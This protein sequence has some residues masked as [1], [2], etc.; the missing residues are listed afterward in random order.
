LKKSG[1]PIRNLYY[2]LCYAWDKLEITGLAG[3][4]TEGQHNATNLLARILVTSAS[5]VVRRGI[6]RSYVRRSEM[7]RTI[8][9]R[10]DA[11]TTIARSELLKG[12]VCCE[13]EEFDPDVLHN[14]IMKATLRCLLKTDGV[15]AANRNEA[16]RLLHKLNEVS[17]I[18]LSASAFR[19]VQLHRNN[20]FYAVVLDTCELLYL[21][22]LPSSDG[23]R[24]VIHEFGGALSDMAHLFE[25]FVANFYR[26][27][28]R[29]YAVKPM[30]LDFRELTGDATALAYV[31]KMRTDIIL[32]SLNHSIIID[33]KFYKDAFRGKWKREHIRTEHLYQISAYARNFRYTVS[34][35]MRLEA[36]LLYPVV[37]R[38]TPLELIFEGFDVKVRFI[39]L[40]QDWPL[41]HRD[42]LRIIGLFDP[43]GLKET[44]GPR[45]SSRLTLRN[46]RTHG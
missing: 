27:R 21:N 10:F 14:R 38:E 32:R 20:A 29:D 34:E 6:D 11:T 28:Q 25:R 35:K 45:L 5:F 16:V 36:I 33:C 44:I 42:L 46:L 13:Y 9:G 39:N 1:I 18:E 19:R 3:A 7:L 2:L 40:N 12:R 24:Y 4:F 43:D 37:K 30:Y 15:A 23:N 17:D 31:P 22:L 26:R 41:I 8:R